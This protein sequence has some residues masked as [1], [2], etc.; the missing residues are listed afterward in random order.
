M[1]NPVLALTRRRQ[2]EVAALAQ[3]KY[4]YRQR[5]FLVEGVRAVASA[6]QAGAPLEMIVVSAD[7]LTDPGWARL[8]S[9]TAVPV[10]QAEATVM[11]QLTDVQTHQGILA[12]ARMPKHTVEGIAD[13]LTVL[14]L[15]AVQDPGNVGTLIRTAAWFGVDAVL[16][17]AGTVD[18]YSPKVV[19]AT[20]G[21]LWD[22]ALVPVGA[23][24]EALRTLCVAGFT[25]YGADLS[26]QE[27]RYWNPVKPSVLVLGSEA[28]GLS[29]EV[30]AVLDRRVCI[31]MG[32]GAQQGVESLNVS[33]AGG[34]LMRQW[35]GRDA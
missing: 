18:G 35:M 11:A 31:G 29:P 7:R 5:A 19:R 22:L 27:A 9:D 21:G 10:Y 12:V 26:G 24:D 23:L 8:L 20:M 6:L 16:L 4:R 34:I 13:R 17:G 3:K 33:V 30:A 1:S 15:D 32:D 2:K 25:C 28:H 14:A